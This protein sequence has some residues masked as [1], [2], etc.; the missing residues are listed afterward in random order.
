VLRAVAYAL[1]TLAMAKLA[2]SLPV[3]EKTGCVTS[4]DCV[5]DRIC[6]EGQ[7]SS[8]ACVATCE[9]ACDRVAECE[10][11]GAAGDCEAMCTSATGVLPGF[12]ERDCKAEWDL[13]VDDEC[14]VAQC[15]L[16]CHALCLYADEKCSLIVDVPACTIGCQHFAPNCSVPTPM[17]CS[18]VPSAVQC[19]EAGACP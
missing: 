19:Y 12:D 1:A 2:C 14:E 16:D 11:A 8:G 4:E 5:E 6:D 9:E 3:D 7:C 10:L 13:L 18:D 15:L 17:E